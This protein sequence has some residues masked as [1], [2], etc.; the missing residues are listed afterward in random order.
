MDKSGQERIEEPERCHCHSHAVHH[1][2]PHKVL[3][4]DPA[5]ATSNAQSLDQFCEIASNQDHIRTLVSD[6]GP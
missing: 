2:R 5:T 6:I 1:E 4:D 3:H